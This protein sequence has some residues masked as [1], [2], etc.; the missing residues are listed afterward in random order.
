MKKIRQYE[1]HEREES[2]RKS[3]PSPLATPRIS[4]SSAGN[5]SLD[6]NSPSQNTIK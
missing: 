6:K 1:E 2:M 4:Q 5:K 3:H